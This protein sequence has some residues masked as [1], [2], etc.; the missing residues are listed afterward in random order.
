MALSDFQRALSEMTVSPNLAARVRAEGERPLAAYDLTPR[1]RARLVAVARHPGMD[2]NCTL[3]RGNRFGPIVDVLPLTCTLLKPW[4]RELLEEL[5]QIKRP[6]N[7]QLSGEEHAFAAFLQAKLAGGELSHPYLAE[8]LEYELASWALVQSLRHT[9]AGDEPQPG[10]EP[11]RL[12]H[13]SHD[14]AL[15]LPPLEAGA[16]PPD[17]LPGGRYPVRVTLRGD[18]LVVEHEAPGW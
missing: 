3:A 5:W 15:L 1:E 4:L 13:F 14:P 6:G 9:S 7:Y 2:L 18:T 16:L 12:V 10:G 17:G 8:V 11:F